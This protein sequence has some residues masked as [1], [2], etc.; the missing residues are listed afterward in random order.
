MGMILSIAL[1]IF[2]G[3]GKD[4]ADHSGHDHSAQEKYETGDHAGHNH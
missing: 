3:C 2:A 1:I 4:E